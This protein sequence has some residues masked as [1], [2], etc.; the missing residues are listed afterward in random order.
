MLWSPLKFMVFFKYFRPN[1]NIKHVAGIRLGT[2][3]MLRASY[4]PSPSRLSTSSTPTPRQA[5][6][7]TPTPKK[8][9][10]AGAT[11]TSLKPSAVAAA[12]EAARERQLQQMEQLNTDNL[13][14]LSSSSKRPRAQDF[15]MKPGD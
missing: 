2:D 7:A 15:F 12:V 9:A 11:P 6:K 5:A 4:T 3:D 8:K 14:N 10:A 13:L 1:L